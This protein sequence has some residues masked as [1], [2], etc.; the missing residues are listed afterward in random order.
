MRPTT[1]FLLAALALTAAPAQAQETGPAGGASVLMGT[2]AAFDG[3]PATFRLSVRPE[4]VLT[5]NEAASLAVVVPITWTTAGETSFGIDTRQSLLEIPVSLRGQLFASS[6]VRMYGDLG[7]GPAFYTAEAEGWFFETQANRTGWMSRSAL[8][9]ELGKPRG[10]IF[11]VVE[12]I[13]LTRYQ[14]GDDEISTR[15]SA[16]IGIGGRG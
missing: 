3:D 7:L 1:P 10:G 13:G 15:Y 12:P 14:F 11:A 16:M 2:G 6:P 8:G 9:V 4:A 5:G